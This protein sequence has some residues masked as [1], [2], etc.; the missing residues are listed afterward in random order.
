MPAIPT[1]P[2]AVDP[3]AEAMTDEVI[4]GPISPLDH[5]PGQTNQDNN[6][7]KQSQKNHPQQ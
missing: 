3:T 4:I 7:H 2:V 6:C 5:Y 1:E